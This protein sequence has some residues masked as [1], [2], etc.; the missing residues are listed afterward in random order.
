LPWKRT[1]TAN[2]VWEQLTPR[3]SREIRAALDHLAMSPDVDSEPNV[4]TLRIGSQP[5][6]VLRLRNGYRVFFRREDE[7]IVVFDIASPAQI[8]FF[9]PAHDGAA[10]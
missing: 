3:Q 4:G 7:Q 9:R 6:K 5:V 8:D 2:M 1:P 10:A